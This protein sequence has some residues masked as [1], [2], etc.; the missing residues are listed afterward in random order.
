MSLKYKTIKTHNTTNNTINNVNNVN[1]VKYNRYI[2]GGIHNEMIN[3]I[4][5][6]KNAMYNEINAELNFTQGLSEITNNNGSYIDSCLRFQTILISKHEKYKF[7]IKALF[8]RNCKLSSKLLDILKTINTLKTD[9]IIKFYG[10]V[11]CNHAYSKNIIKKGLFKT[12]KNKNK[13]FCKTIGN[14]KIALLFFQYFEDTQS[15]KSYIL[16]IF[17]NNIKTEFTKCMRLCICIIVLLY[18]ANITIGFVHHDLNLRNILINKDIIT[19]KIFKLPEIPDDYSSYVSFICPYIIDIDETSE[20]LHFL[21]GDKLI[22]YLN[23]I[24]INIMNTII[25]ENNYILGI[26][27]NTINEIII[28]IASVEYYEVFTIFEKLNHIIFD[29]QTEIDLILE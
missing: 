12:F 20:T 8:G 2:G 9:N 16:D 29:S 13:E 26:I 28:N 4:N 10:I 7:I 1:N 25:C 27:Y 11:S 21:K 18:Y 19:P 22:S 24:L 5:T 3:Y 6:H 14:N 15:V 23:I 17:N